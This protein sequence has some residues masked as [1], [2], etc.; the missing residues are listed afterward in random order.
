[1][2]SDEKMSHVIHLMLDGLEKAGLA[3]FPKKDEALRE[4]KKVGNR[5]LVHLGEAEEAARKRISSMKN[6]P[7]EFSPQYQNLYQKFH[8]EELKKR[9]GGIVE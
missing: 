1:V 9:G 5:Y 2:I 4:A 7:P 3:R 6:A 8:E